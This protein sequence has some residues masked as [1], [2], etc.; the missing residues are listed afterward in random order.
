MGS[1]TLPLPGTYFNVTGIYARG[2]RQRRKGL[3]GIHISD[4]PDEMIFERCRSIHTFGMKFDLKII[5][6]D[7]D[8]IV[9]GACIVCPRR[10]IV[11]PRSTFTIVEQPL[12]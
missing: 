9:L 10:I 4:A 12:R 3:A 8:N 2:Y 5:F 11:A 6:L 7:R 1:R